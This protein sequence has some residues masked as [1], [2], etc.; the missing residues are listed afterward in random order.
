MFLEPTL[1]SRD[2]RIAVKDTTHIGFVT[3]TTKHAKFHASEMNIGMNVTLDGVSDVG[4][5]NTK[6][7][8]H[9]HL[10]CTLELL[11]P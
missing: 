11:S 3:H 10:L 4:C 1:Q 7:F 2:L 6:T 8:A 9:W 5:A